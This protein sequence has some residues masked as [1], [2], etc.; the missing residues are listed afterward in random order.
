MR[1]AEILPPQFEKAVTYATTAHAGQNR[2]DGKTPYIEHPLRVAGFLWQHGIQDP[3]IITAALLHDVVEDTRRTIADILEEF[4]LGVARLVD[5]LT[6][7]PRTTRREY[8]QSFSFAFP[9]ACIIKA[10]DRIDNL[11]DW[12]GMDSDYRARYAEEGIEIVGAIRE[13]EA[14]HGWADDRA[15]LILGILLGTCDRYRK[16]HESKPAYAPP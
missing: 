3:D 2:K 15:W 14:F 4:G 1:G 10:A 12:A 9:E 8:V 13:N 5:D 11:N 16:A 7:E 6:K